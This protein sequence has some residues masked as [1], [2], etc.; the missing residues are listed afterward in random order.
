MYLNNDGT[1]VIQRG[2]NPHDMRLV[3]KRASATFNS[4]YI[5][6]QNED[7]DT[8]GGVISGAYVQSHTN[9][10]FYIVNDRPLGDIGFRT[11][12]GGSIADRMTL[13]NAGNL[14]IGIAPTHK[15]DVAGT[16]RASG[17]TTLQD[18]LIVNTDGKLTHVHDLQ[19]DGVLK[20]KDGEAGTA[21]QI[22]SSTSTATDWI[23]LSAAI[24]DASEDGKGL[25]EL[26]NAAE[27]GAL[28]SAALAISPL[29]LN[30]AF[31]KTTVTTPSPGT[32][33]KLPGGLIIQHGVI[34]HTG[35][36]ATVTFPVPFTSASSYS[37][38]GL[39]VTTTSREVSLHT[40]SKTGCTFKMSTS[41][42][43]VEWLAIGF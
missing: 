43:P 13:S 40:K 8:P 28:S 36:L 1:L 29:R 7:P 34:T 20:D 16:F 14:G 23:S 33:W 6:W 24:S 22:L 19:I 15:L 31:V 30:D 42:I 9:G 5:S 37:I 27:A 21:G 38:S 3:L 32:E 12:I 2:N 41:S 17:I 35:T 11:R 39:P 26:A 10:T 18:N 25:V 4:P